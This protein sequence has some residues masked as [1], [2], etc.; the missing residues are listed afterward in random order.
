MTYVY[1]D[2]QLTSYAYQNPEILAVYGENLGELPSINLVNANINWEGVAG[3]P[4]DLS[5]FGTNLGDEE[6]YGYVPGLGT[7][8]LETA[9]L[10]LGMRLSSRAYLSFERGLSGADNLVKINYTLTKRVSVQAQAGSAAALDLLYTLS[11]K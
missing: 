5:L 3:L 6:Y 9:V 11:F 8:G 7:A 1:I 10:T 4:L 2:K